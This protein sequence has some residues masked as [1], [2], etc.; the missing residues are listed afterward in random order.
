MTVQPLMNLNLLFYAVES[1]QT[2]Q[3]QDSC[4]KICVG[5]YNLSLYHF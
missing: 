5:M 1:F 3:M 4:R 2:P